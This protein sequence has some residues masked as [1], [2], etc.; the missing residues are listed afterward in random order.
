M[1]RARGACERMVIMR[2]WMLSWTLAL[3]GM[4]ALFTHEAL[5]QDKGASPRFKPETAAESDT[6]SDTESVVDKLVQFAMPGEHHK[7]LEKMAGEWNMAIK[8]RMKCDAP[9][10]ESEGTCRRK[11][12][13]GG[14]FLL[15]EFDGGNLGLPFQG[16]A[17]YGYD[18]F[19]KKY[20]SVWVDTLNTAITTNMGTCQNSC[21]LITFVGRHGDPWTGVKK[22][23]R[24]ITHFINDDRHTLE[25]HEP[26]VDGKE[27][28]IL[29][30]VYT[31]K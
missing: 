17:I 13:L 3:G 31:R 19:E 26:G 10:V 27:F 20:T 11:W 14:R 1:R 16:L 24:G 12:I 29:E 28:K 5:S 21:E 8:Y 15:E 25:L 30:I 23:S 7:L 2:L 22:T 6:G 4:T 18:S 9:V